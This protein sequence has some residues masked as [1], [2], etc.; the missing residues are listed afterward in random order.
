MLT[1]G[2]VGVLRYSPFV[3]SLG[4]PVQPIALRVADPW[5]VNHDH[6]FTNWTSGYFW[7]L[8]WFLAAPWYVFTFQQHTCPVPRLFLHPPVC[9]Q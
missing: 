2:T 5:P 1:S 7:N 6:A 9:V 3:F 4:L 8:F